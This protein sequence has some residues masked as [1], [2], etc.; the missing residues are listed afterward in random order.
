MPGPDDSDGR[1]VSHRRISNGIGTYH[2]AHEQYYL[3][4][5]S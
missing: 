2:P 5:F 3:D 4:M 1:W